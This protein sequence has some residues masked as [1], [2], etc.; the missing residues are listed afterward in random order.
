MFDIFLL[1][2]MLEYDKTEVTFSMCVKLKEISIFLRYRR[3]EV[4]GF[5]NHF[6]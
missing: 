2:L 6:I 1:K 3:N 4:V 5:K